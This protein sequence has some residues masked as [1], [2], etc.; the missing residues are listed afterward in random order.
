MTTPI[1]AAEILYADIT[2]LQVIMQRVVAQ[3]AAQSGHDI[4]KVMR[5]E[6]AQASIELAKVEFVGVDPESERVELIRNHA[7]VLLDS[8]YSNG[9][10]F[11]PPPRNGGQ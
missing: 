8:I 3:L 10:T 1:T 11:A 5:A 6:H 9:A 2:A 7:Q 4:A